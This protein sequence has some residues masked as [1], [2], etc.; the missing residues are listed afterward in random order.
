M[1]NARTQHQPDAK[2]LLMS[3][4]PPLR[5]LIFYG[6]LKFFPQLAEARSQ[7]SEFSFFIFP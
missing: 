2:F 5:P 3:A 6:G 4:S 1:N 7:I